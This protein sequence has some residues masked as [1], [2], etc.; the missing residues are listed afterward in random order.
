MG[1]DC[2]IGFGSFSKSFSKSDIKGKL[3]EYIVYSKKKRVCGPCLS[4]R[5]QYVSREYISS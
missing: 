1:C 5:M 4:V 2:E 3:S